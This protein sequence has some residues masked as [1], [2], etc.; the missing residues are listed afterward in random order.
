MKTYIPPLSKPHRYKRGSAHPNKPV[1][2]RQ[3]DWVSGLQKITKHNSIVK[4][5]GTR[6]VKNFDMHG[7]EQWLD[8]GLLD[9]WEGK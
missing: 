8:V 7:D 2:I 6:V 1:V 5:D 9:K 4:P 3:K